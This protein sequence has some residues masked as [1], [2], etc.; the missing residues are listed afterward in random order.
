MNHIKFLVAQD[1]KLL[2]NDQEVQQEI[3][4][5][6]KKLLG[7]AAEQMLVI[8]PTIMKNGAILTKEQ[9][10]KLIEPIT[11]EEICNIVQN[12]DD[13]KAPGCDGFNACFF[14]KA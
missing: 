1:G 2:Q 14:K 8:N 7:D 9:Q 10:L 11:T 12:I 4:G 5:F 13:N 3:V 6:Y